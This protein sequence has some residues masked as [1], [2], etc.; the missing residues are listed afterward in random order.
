[1]TVDERVRDML[2]RH[3]PDSPNARAH[4]WREPYLFDA[5]GRVCARLESSGVAPS[6]QRILLA[7]PAELLRGSHRCPG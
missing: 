7:D 1:M 4:R 3:G 5:A 6:E 2:L